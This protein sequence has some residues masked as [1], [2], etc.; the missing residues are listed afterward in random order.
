[1]G[2]GGRE[3]GGRGGSYVHAY[4]LTTTW[5]GVD[6]IKLETDASHGKFESSNA[7]FREETIQVL[8]NLIEVCT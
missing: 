6:G 8:C 1:M 4:K 5:K 3:G 7:N 2:R